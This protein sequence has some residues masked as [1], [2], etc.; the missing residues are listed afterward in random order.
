MFH[1]ELRQSLHVTRTL[2]LSAE[3][4]WAQIVGPWVSDQEVELGDR[5]WSP[6]RARL[7]IYEAPALRTEELGLGRGWSNATKSGHDVTTRVLAEARQARDAQQGGTA[8]RPS[9]TQLKQDVLACCASEPVGLA[10]LVPLAS[11][12]FP[13]RRVSAHLALVEQSVW[14]LLHEGRAMLLRAGAISQ[15]IGREQWEAVLLAWE[16]WTPDATPRVQL[17]TGFGAPGAVDEQASDL[18][19]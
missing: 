13:G 10:E 19:D 2:N 17:L 7:T 4:L 3:E 15:P 8:D 1:V 14:E 9:I 6:E 12:R 16:T 5:R 11:E 18:T